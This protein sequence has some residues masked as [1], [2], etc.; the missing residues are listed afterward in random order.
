METFN[1]TNDQQR[2]LC[3]K[4]LKKMKHLGVHEQRIHK[5]LENSR[6]NWRCGLESALVRFSA[7]LAEAARQHTPGGYACIQR[8][9]SLAAVVKDATLTSKQRVG[10]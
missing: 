10:G 5:C 7:I 6:E 1:A 2:R 4:R 3:S 9:C 8:L